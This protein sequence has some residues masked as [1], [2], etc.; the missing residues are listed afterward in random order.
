MHVSASRHLRSMF[1][2]GR[3]EHRR[4]GHITFRVA[5]PVGCAPA[6][7]VV[8]PVQHSHSP[9]GV[10]VVPLGRGAHCSYGQVGQV[11]S[12]PQG[13]LGRREVEEPPLTMTA[14]PAPGSRR[15]FCP[16]SG[17][18]LTG[19]SD[20]AWNLSKRCPQSSHSYSY[21]GMVRSQLCAPI[22]ADIAAAFQPIVCRRRP[23][24]R[25]GRGR[26]RGGHLRP[27]R[28]PSPPWSAR[29]GR[30]GGSGSSV[31]PAGGR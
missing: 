28:R 31:S 5:R 13:G 4:F 30:A 2:S 27:S 15:T 16:Q 11:A 10:V 22:I 29:P 12:P 19:R 23:A 21:V 9:V 20:I 26:R 14:A 25:R 8:G 24:W 6:V 1:A 7:Q 3:R 18:F 17:H